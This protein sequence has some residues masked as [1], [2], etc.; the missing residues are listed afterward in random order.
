MV[1]YH[2]GVL[3]SHDQNAD[4]FASMVYLEL[5]HR[6]PELLLTRADKMTMAASV[7]ARVPFLD[8][9][10]VEF[11]LQIPTTLKYRNGIT[12]YILKA[13]EGIIPHA[14]IY[15]KKRWVLFLQQ[16]IG[17]NKAAILKRIF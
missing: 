5:K 17:L 8:D 3:H 4:F 16:H 10:L 9:A 15:K 1:D 12:K 11:A 13:A 2:L 6:L 7:E 14:T